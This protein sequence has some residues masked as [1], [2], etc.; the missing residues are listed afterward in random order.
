MFESGALEGIEIVGI[1]VIIAHP[2]RVV[3][4]WTTSSVVA[5]VLLSQVLHTSFSYR[6]K[7]QKQRMVMI[8]PTA[9][10]LFSAEGGQAQLAL[11]MQNWLLMVEHRYL[12][13]GETLH[14]SNHSRMLEV[15]LNLPFPSKRRKGF[16]D[17]LLFPFPNQR[18][19]LSIRA[20]RLG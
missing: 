1:P 2:R 16:L 4:S 5:R 9:A 6:Q 7:H 8:R 17:I 12:L 11:R 14:R 15:D 13:Q 10:L 3:A 20:Q 19:P 18:V